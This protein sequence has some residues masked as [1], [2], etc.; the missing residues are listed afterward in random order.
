MINRKRALIDVL[1]YSSLF[2]IFL[3]YNHLRLTHAELTSV[4]VAFAAFTPVAVAWHYFYQK[5][6]E[7]E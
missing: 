2:V 1:G 5:F 7:K 4:A 6:S 3:L